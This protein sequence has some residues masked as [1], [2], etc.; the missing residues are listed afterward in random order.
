MYVLAILL[1]RLNNK[2]RNKSFLMLIHF[3]ISSL[4]KVKQINC[5]YSLN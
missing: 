2:S 4:V 3:C 5:F 1:L